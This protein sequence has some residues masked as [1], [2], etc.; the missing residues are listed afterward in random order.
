[1]KWVRR[2][3]LLFRVAWMFFSAWRVSYLYPCINKA[4]KRFLIRTAV[5][6][7]T[8]ERFGEI[9]PKWKNQPAREQTDD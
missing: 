7:K 4:A 9:R 5:N 3:G 8:Y 2:L 6:D 1:M